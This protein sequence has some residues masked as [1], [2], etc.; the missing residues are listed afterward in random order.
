MAGSPPPADAN[1]MHT[2]HSTLARTTVAALVAALSLTLGATAYA[3]P[4]TASAALPTPA[5][6][7]SIVTTLWTQREGVL[8]RLDAAGL[9]PYETGAAAELDTAYINDVRCGCDPAKDS[10]VVLKVVPAVPKSSPKATFFAEVRTTNGRTKAHP[11]YVV[12]VTRAAG[13]WKFAFITFGT[14]A[15]APPL[16]ELGTTGVNTPAVNA[17]TYARS[18]RMASFTAASETAQDEKPTTNSYGATV[19]G[20]AKIDGARDGVF[21]LALSSSKVLSCYTLHVLDTTSLAAGLQQDTAQQQWGGTLAPG[22]YSSVTVDVATPQCMVG[23]GAG[24]TPGTLRMQYDDTILGATG[25]P[26]A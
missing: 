4:S 11:W 7:T 5:A 3:Q 22:N 16:P 6:A 20:R 13:T 18:S 25:V 24:A 1:D 15:T 23:T 14:N 12:A 9:A 19:Q 2:R 21:G 17:A 10:H 8:T 26:I